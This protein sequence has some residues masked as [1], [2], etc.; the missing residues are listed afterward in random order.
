MKPYKDKILNES[1]RVRKFNSKVKPSELVWHRDQFDRV[2]EVHKSNNWLLQIDN[3]LPKRL[4]EGSKYIIPAKSWHRII[5]GKGNLIVVINEIKKKKKKD[6]SQS[7]MTSYDDEDDDYFYDDYYVDEDDEDYYYDDFDYY[8]DD[9]DDFDDYDIY[10]NVMPTGRRNPLYIFDFDD[11]L[12]L[13]DSHVRVIDGEGNINRLDSREF[14]KYRPS[15]GDKLDFTEFTR[16]SGTLINNTVAEMENAISRFGFSNVFIVTAR[17]VGEPVTEFLQS[18]GV[19]TPQVVATA[20]SAGKAT[21]LKEKLISGDYDE[22]HVYEDCQKNIQMLSEVVEE[23]NRTADE[24]SYPKVRYFS[25]CI[26]AE[27]VR[28]RIKQ[29][30]LESIDQDKKMYIDDSPIHGKGVFLKLD[31]PKG[32]NLGMAQERVPDGY[33]ISTLGKYHNHSY[34]P[35][36]DNKMVGNKR[37]LVTNKNLKAGDEITVDYTFQPDLEQPK[38]SWS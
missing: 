18:V 27:A 3:Q 36:C 38:D 14:A 19:S 17:A 11:T 26:I 9:Y 1:V 15:P 6:L 29:I 7:G 23:F 24:L 10:E 37:Y 31:M 8:D 30:M 22:V 28:L 2:I 21:W 4:A 33:K 32:T 16:A 25:T 5:K 20:G 12:A 34:D 35:T 13:T